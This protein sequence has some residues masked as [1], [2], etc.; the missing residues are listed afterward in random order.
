MSVPSDL[1]S[2]TRRM[3][4]QILICRPHDSVS[5]AVQYYYDERCPN[6]AVN[7]AIHS[8]L[9]LLRKPVDFRSAIGT[10]YCA[11]TA[12]SASAPLLGKEHT[13]N[14]GSKE[15]KESDGI[16]K[17]IIVSDR[18]SENDSERGSPIM[19]ESDP[20]FSSDVVGE[21]VHLDSLCR[22]ARL[23]ISS[24]DAS[25]AVAAGSMRSD[26]LKNSLEPIP[27]AEDKVWLF[28]LI[29]RSLRKDPISEAVNL[30]FE[31][32]ISFLRLYLGLWTVVAWLKRA[33]TS[34]TTMDSSNAKIDVLTEDMLATRS[35][36]GVEDDGLLNNV[37][38]ED[39]DVL[40]NLL[41]SVYNTS[42]P[43]EKEEVDTIITR[44]FEQYFGVVMSSPT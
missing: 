26:L 35:N 31:A 25:L 36:I 19:V 33:T 4:E 13:P 40:K 21:A 44:C 32:Y 24:Y 6:P 38:Q 14:Q 16:V 10:I 5:Y 18:N 2:S 23:A 7:H 41:T 30:D 17:D 43:E 12:A 11:E 22:I 20:A 27:G 9:Y 8:L 37:L 28:E 42:T 34:L 15:A 3:I 39:E 1:R 29:E